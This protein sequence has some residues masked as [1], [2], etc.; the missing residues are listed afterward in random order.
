MSDFIKGIY[1]QT[2]WSKEDWLTYGDCP[3]C[4]DNYLTELNNLDRLYYY[5]PNDMYVESINPIT[6]NIGESYRIITR[7]NKEFTLIDD[8]PS[9]QRLV[10]QNE[11]DAKHIDHLRGTPPGILISFDF[12]RKSDGQPEQVMVLAEGNHRAALSIREHQ[13]LCV[14][15]FDSSETKELIV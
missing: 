3:K 9:L 14:F 5:Q 6:I 1:D 11:I 4:A 12:H 15:Y 13:P 10:D 8:L 2:G 7:K